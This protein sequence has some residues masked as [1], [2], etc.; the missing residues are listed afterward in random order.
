MSGSG[1]T[2]L[3]ALALVGDVKGLLRVKC[4]HYLTKCVFWGPNQPAVTPG[5]SVYI[6]SK[7]PVMVL[8]ALVVARGGFIA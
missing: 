4:F 3:S 2:I 7:P 5:K 6:K 8:S 1:N